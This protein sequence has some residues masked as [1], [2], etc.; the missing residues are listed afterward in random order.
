M[1]TYS[2]VLLTLA[3]ARRTPDPANAVWASIG[4]AL[5]D[6]P[7][8]AGGLWLQAR[9]KV[10]FTRE[11]FD[12]KVCGRRRFRAS[13]AALHSTPPVAA[14]LALYAIPGAR[15]RDPLR[16]LLA[17]LLGWAGHVAASARDFS[18]HGREVDAMVDRDRVLANM[19]DALARH[20]ATRA[21]DGRSISRDPRSIRTELSLS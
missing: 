15:N 3:A 14:A 7:A 5:L 13:D 12:E 9:W 4:A 2:H 19:M 10:P 20:P 6:I 1:R 18:R 8:L 21:S 17:F 11:R 16:V